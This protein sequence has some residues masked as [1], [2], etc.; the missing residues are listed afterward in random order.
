MKKPVPFLALLL[1]GWVL[2][3][4]SPSYKQGEHG[5]NAGGHPDAGV[6]L[7]SS[8]YRIRLDAVGEGVVAP[9]LASGSFR[10]DGGFVPAYPPPG[11]VLGLRFTDRQTLRWNPERSVGDYSVYRDLVSALSGLGF[12][13]CLDHHVV[14]EGATDT[15]TPGAGQGYFYLVTA[16]NRLDEE[17]T[18]GFRSNGMERP[19]HAPCP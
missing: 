1:A 14:Q 17:G 13:S 6:S 2:A 12:G 18:K 15:Q 4:E 16:E 10:M 19:N 8:S 11:E 9:G 7:S 3:Q 5:L